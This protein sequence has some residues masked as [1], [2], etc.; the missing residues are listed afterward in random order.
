[1]SIIY[2]NLAPAG[3]IDTEALP[4]TYAYNADGTLAS[5]TVSFLSYTFVKSYQYTNGKLTSQSGWVK[6]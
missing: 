6:Q 1:M 3:F 5:E 2:T 4:T